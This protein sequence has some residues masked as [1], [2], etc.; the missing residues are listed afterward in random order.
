VPKHV[1][2]NR[3]LLG[4]AIYGERKD[5]EPYYQNPHFGPAY[6]K[7]VGFRNSIWRDISITLTTK[8]IMGTIDDKTTTP[9]PMAKARMRLQT[10][11]TTS[12]KDL[13][14]APRLDDEIRISGGMG[15]LV[16]GGSASFKG[17][18]LESIK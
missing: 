14:E 5:G 7:P 15:L 16:V 11:I 2:G 1:E 9:R 12:L 10:D 3:L 17:V 4:H 13:I 6:F 18:T 8:E